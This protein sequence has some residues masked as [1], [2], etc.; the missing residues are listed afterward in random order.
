MYPL[1]NEINCSFLLLFICFLYHY[2]ALYAHSQKFIYVIHQHDWAGD[3]VV[4][5]ACACVRF[6]FL[7]GGG[8]GHILIRE[9]C[10][11]RL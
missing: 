4:V 3:G 10:Q 6:C 9:E 1:E 11:Q 2:Y 5:F 8:G 7:G